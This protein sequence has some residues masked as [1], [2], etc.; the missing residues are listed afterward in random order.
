MG[1]NV[2]AIH[3]LPLSFLVLT[4][5]LKRTLKKFST[6]AVCVAWASGDVL[7]DGWRLNWFLL[8]VP[9][10]ASAPSRVTWL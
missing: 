8:S 7:I 2:T 1:T 5:M 10:M 4:V 6:C 9:A 3:A